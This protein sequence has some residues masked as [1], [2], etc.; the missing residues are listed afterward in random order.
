MNVR[1]AI[2]F[3]RSPGGLEMSEISQTRKSG[4]S[5]GFALDRPLCY[6][7]HGDNPSGEPGYGDVGVALPD[8]KFW[9]REATML[10]AGLEFTGR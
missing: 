1:Y 9:N 5:T 6:H 4:L 7:C 2:S 10:V 3:G 8:Q